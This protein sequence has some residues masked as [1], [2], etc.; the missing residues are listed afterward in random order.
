MAF[1]NTVSLAPL[2]VVVVA[3]GGGTMRNQSLGRSFTVGPSGCLL[4]GFRPSLALVVVAAPVLHTYFSLGSEKWS[5]QKN[6]ENEMICS[7]DLMERGRRTFIVFH[8]WSGVCI[9]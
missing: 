7:L 9:C 4:E 3:L 2:V 6:I 1:H 8:L 5:A